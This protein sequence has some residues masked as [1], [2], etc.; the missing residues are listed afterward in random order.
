MLACTNTGTCWPL[1]WLKLGT[2][3]TC[4]GGVAD[5]DGGVAAAAEEEE[6]GLSGL[7]ADAELGSSNPFSAS[8][9]VSMLSAAGF[10]RDD[11]I[12]QAG[13]E[14][15][16]EAVVGHSSAVA[17][18]ARGRSQLCAHWTAGARGRRGLRT[19]FRLRGGAGSPG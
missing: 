7:A 19:G 18:R 17:S 3:N 1:D 13:D 14:L 15:G 2:A 5:A 4:R 16:E 9:L 12:A 10:D 8:W 6:E 11:T